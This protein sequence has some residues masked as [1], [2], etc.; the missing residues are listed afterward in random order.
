M[1][2]KK[3]ISSEERMKKWNS[4][5]EHFTGPKSQWKLKNKDDSKKA[6]K[7]LIER[8]GTVF[9]HILVNASTQLDEVFHSEKCKYAP[10][11]LSLTKPWKTRVQWQ[12]WKLE[13][14]KILGIEFST[15]INEKLHNLFVNDSKKRFLKR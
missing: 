9:H 5:F 1:L 12:L 2:S 13:L 7:N 4:C 15:E 8:A 3:D 11:R 10:K 14:A 6:L